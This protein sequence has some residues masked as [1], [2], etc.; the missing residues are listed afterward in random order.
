MV[1]H[2][3]DIFTFLYWASCGPGTLVS[4]CELW[5]VNSS[6]SWF[7]HRFP[8]RCGSSFLLD[9]IIYVHN[10]P[11]QRLLCS[12]SCSSLRACCLFICLVIWSDYFTQVCHLWSVQPVMS[13]GRD[14]S[15]W[16]MHS[17]LAVTVTFLSCPQLSLFLSVPVFGWYHTQLL[18]PKML[19][20]CSIVSDKAPGHKL[21]HSQLQ[22]NSCL[23]A[24]LLFGGLLLSFIPTWERLTASFL[25]FLWWTTNWS[26]ASKH[27]ALWEPKATLI[28]LP[29]NPAL[30]WQYPEVWTPSYS[31]PDKVLS[32]R[33]AQSSLFL[34]SISNP[35]GSLCTSEHWAISF[36][37][38]MLDMQGLRRRCW[39]IFLDCLF[40]HG[41]ASLGMLGERPTLVV[42][43]IW[44]SYHSLNG[45][46]E[47]QAFHW[48]CLKGNTFL[49]YCSV[50]LDCPLG[51]REP[52]ILGCIGWEQ[53]FHH[54]GWMCRKEPQLRP[55][56]Y[57][58]PWGLQ[59]YF[60]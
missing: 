56:S 42:C 53:S 5:P 54:A 7:C 14:H 35:Q 43:G 18:A 1:G 52:G 3:P 49:T 37:W 44:A 17:H 51:I 6:K 57:C 45:S 15:P 47:P 46:W 4:C 48:P 26:I 16:G 28:F 25:V 20:H 2:F 13:P 38:P 55:H 24:G 8:P 23:F 10:W 22:L 59:D 31:V 32:R 36:E 33:A 58:S 39:T 12:N 27:V 30:L 41:A 19:A 11:L 21:L 34:E 29:V 60:C 50:S 40:R 9:L